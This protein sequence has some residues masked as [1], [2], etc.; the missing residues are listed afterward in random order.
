[1]TFSIVATDRSAQEVGFAIAS[2]CWDAGQVCMAKAEVG[3]IASQAHGN[4]AFLPAFFDRLSAGDDPD[5]ILA[6]FRANDD[7]IAQ[8]QIGMITQAGAPVAFT[9]ERCA[10]WAG[11]VTGDDFACQGNTLVGSE[12]IDAMAEAFD[13]SNGALYE[14]LC[15]ALRAGDDAGGDVRGKQSARLLVAKRGFGQPGTDTF[16]DVRIEDHAEPVRE[17]GRILGV[18]GTL[19]HI[20]G[21]L[22][23][24]EGAVQTDKPEI[25]DRLHAYLDDKR[26]RRYLDWWESLGLAYHGIGRPDQ[27]V[28]AFGVYLSINPA[29]A[30]VLR[31]GAAKG[32]FPRDLAGA[33]GLAD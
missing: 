23:Q 3:A 21:L 2:C 33:L 7:E 28:A 11:H 5:A 14:R 10:T 16:L 24:F 32:V 1:M 25:L 8:R 31:D 22:E 15:A 29:M 12:V 27:A 19:L 17:I 4:L 26:D 30:D 18:G 9:G 20:F 6:G 13:R